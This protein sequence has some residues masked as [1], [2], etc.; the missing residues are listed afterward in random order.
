MSP[1]NRRT[2]AFGFSRANFW[3]NKASVFQEV[4]EG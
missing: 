2:T 1:E 4:S 3:E